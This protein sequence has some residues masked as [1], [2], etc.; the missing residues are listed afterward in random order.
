MGDGAGLYA[1]ETKGKMGDGGGL[2]LLKKLA[3]ESTTLVPGMLPGTLSPLQLLSSSSSSPSS[4]SSSLSL[5]G[6]CKG[7]A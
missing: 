6:L 7:W 1:M 4:S 5:F 2:W 3:M